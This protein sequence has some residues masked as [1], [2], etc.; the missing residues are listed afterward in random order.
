MAKLLGDAESG[1]EGIKLYL[2]SC[3]VAQKNPENHDWMTTILPHLTIISH[4]A[5]PP[6]P[7]IVFRFTV[8]PVHCNGLGNLHGGCAAT[9]FD[10]CTSLPLRLVSRPGFWQF[11][12]VS[13]T[14]GVT[15][16][17]PVPAGSTV[18]VECELLQVGRRLCTA[19]GV[20]RLAAGEGAGEGEEGKDR[21]VLAICEHGKVN[22]DPA[23][24][25]L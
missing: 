3:L 18:D 15:Y 2:E 4:S 11:M 19:R 23:A 9:I 20:M 22:V 6:H 5:S 1:I 25:K 21:P 8:Q 12:G 17:Q 10:L 7:R 24:E 16:L 13:R 14:L